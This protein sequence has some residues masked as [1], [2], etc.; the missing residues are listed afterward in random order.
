M[1]HQE[2]WNQLITSL[3]QM[4]WV[5]V[6]AVITGI[7]YIILAAQEQIWCWFFGIVSSLLSIYLFFSVKLY[8]ESFLYFYYVLAGFY[9][10]YTWRKQEGKHDLPITNRSWIFHILCMVLG[11]ICSF[12]L[13]Q[14][15]GQYT[16]AQMPLID[17]H[18]TVF[19]FIATWLVTQ[20][21]LETWTYWIVIDAVSV[22]LYWSRDL[23]L[24]SLLMVVY[25][26]LAIWAFWAWKT[27]MEK[28]ALQIPKVE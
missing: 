12:A 2:V 19:S 25:T 3:Q 26:V 21:I 13:A 24:Y 28:E 15:L 18:T 11:V 4:P 9:G 6:L 7:A 17:A 23:Y 1:S 27:Q 10:W 20:K 5:E 8:A 14:A 16:D 22:W